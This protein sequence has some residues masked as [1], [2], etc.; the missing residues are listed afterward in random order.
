MSDF[1]VTG[2]E[3]LEAVAK[4]LK[5]AGSG[6][7]RK[8]LLRGIR[9]TNKPTIADIRA[10]ARDR[11]PHGGGLADIVARSSIGTRTRLSGKNVGVEI[12]GTSGRLRN[13]RNLNAGRL[14]HPLF[15]NRKHY[16]EQPVEPGFFDDPIE[17][18]AD[19]IR[20]GIEEVMADVARKVTQ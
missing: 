10:S 17:K 20:R 9:Q 11:L 13:L 2:A 19:E 12:K 7:L 5:Q 18:R 3:D 6:E 16:Y 14:R 1:R 4:R 8:E 15:G